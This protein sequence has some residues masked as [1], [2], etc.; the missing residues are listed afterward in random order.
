MTHGLM[1]D[2]GDGGLNPICFVAALLTYVD[3]WSTGIA[4]PS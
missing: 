2:V 1:T 4:M 3:I